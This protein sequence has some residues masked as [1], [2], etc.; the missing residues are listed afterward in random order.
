MP[1][2]F[3]QPSAFIWPSA[4]GWLTGVVATGAA[5]VCT[6]PARETW[7]GEIF[8]RMK[9]KEFNKLH[10]IGRN[11]RINKSD[12]AVHNKDQF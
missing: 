10:S 6:L 12:E 7:L 5:V 8:F 9:L 4:S 1:R 11:V 3:I 2:H